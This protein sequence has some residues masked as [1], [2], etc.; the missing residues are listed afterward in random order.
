ML[1]LR[2]IRL[3]GDFRRF[4]HWIFA[5]PTTLLKNGSSMRLSISVLM[6]GLTGSQDFAITNS[7]AGHRAA[8]Q[9]AIESLLT[10]QEAG[11]RL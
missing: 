7:L 6:H 8:T 3:S 10:S 5:V 1:S 2:G 11:S 9:A 4:S